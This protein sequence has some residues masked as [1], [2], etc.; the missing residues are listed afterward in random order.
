[1]ERVELTEE[2]KERI[3]ENA[4]RFALEAGRKYFACA[5]GTLGNM[6]GIQ[7]RGD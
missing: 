2:Q 5:P 4:C 7:G 6:Q 1:M 3:V